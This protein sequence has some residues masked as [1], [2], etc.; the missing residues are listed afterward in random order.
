MNVSDDL[1][2]PDR[3]PDIVCDRCSVLVLNQMDFV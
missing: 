1:L 3:A 2:F